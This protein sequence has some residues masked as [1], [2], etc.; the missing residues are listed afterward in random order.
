MIEMTTH[1]SLNWDQHTMQFA[2]RFGAILKIF[3]AMLKIQKENIQTIWKQRP[4]LCSNYLISWWFKSLEHSHL[5]AKKLTRL[6]LHASMSGYTCL[7]AYLGGN[8]KRG[9]W[10]TK[11][12]R[13]ALEGG[14]ELVNEYTTFENVQ[15]QFLI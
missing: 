14:S 4:W 1:R 7:Q 11:F 8:T 15:I 10:V 12:L 5:Y 13:R 9:K 2:I 6:Y 3:G